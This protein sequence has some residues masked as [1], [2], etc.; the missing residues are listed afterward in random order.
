MHRSPV[1][2]KNEA[3]KLHHWSVR[4]LED[5]FFTTK[6]ALVRLSMF[7]LAML[8]C[9]LRLDAIYQANG[10]ATPSVA[11]S[12]LSQIELGAHSTTRTEAEYIAKQVTG[13]MWVG[14]P[15]FLSGDRV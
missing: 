8:E 11:A 10:T 15:A 12:M 1:Q 2:W 7:P 13:N 4:V 3:K 5:A 14:T 9:K 6:Q